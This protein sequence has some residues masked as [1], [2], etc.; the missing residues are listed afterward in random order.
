MPL[1]KQLDRFDYSGG[2]HRN[3]GRCRVRL[4]G[5]VGEGPT[6]YLVIAT[7]LGD[8]N[9]GPSVT[10][11]AELVAEAVCERFSLSPSEVTFIEHYDGRI[12]NTSPL[13][14]RDGVEDYDQVLFQTDR[15]PLASPTWRPMRKHEVEAL[16]G[17]ALP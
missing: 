4:Y 2:R 7:D 16:V 9:P 10:N 15:R 14:R 8:E 17:E 12:G 5:T 13:R 6:P 1:V 11:A 3:E